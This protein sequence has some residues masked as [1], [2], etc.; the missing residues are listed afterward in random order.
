[1]QYQYVERGGI[2]YALDNGVEV[3]W[4][5]QAVASLQREKEAEAAALEE[6]LSANKARRKLA[7]L[8][9]EEAQQVLATAGIPLDENGVPIPQEE[10]E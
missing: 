3:L 5:E 7:K 10:G 2:L 1:M 4:G 6:L 8:T 9:E